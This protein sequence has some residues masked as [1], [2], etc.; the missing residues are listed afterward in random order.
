MS[1]EGVC[2]TVPATPGLLKRRK[3]L[4]ESIEVVAPADGDLEEAEDHGGDNPNVET[5]LAPKEVSNG[6]RTFQFRSFLD[7]ISLPEDKAAQDDA[8]HPQGVKV[9]DQMGIS[10]NPV[11]FSSESVLEL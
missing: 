11:V 3:Y 7:T 2:R 4:K 6:A 8:N 9:T 5:C 10:T 1:D